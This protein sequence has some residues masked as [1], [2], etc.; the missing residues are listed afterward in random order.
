MA[1]AHSSGDAFLRLER[2]ARLP[3]RLCTCF[4]KT[5]ASGSLLAIALQVD[6][7]PPTPLKEMNDGK[8][9]ERQKPQDW[10]T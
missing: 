1:S 9:T 5:A 4:A 10:Q 8:F 6:M 3:A 7:L 2:F